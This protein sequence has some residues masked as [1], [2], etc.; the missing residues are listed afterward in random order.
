MFEIAAHYQW[1]DHQISGRFTELAADGLIERTGQTRVK[2][3]TQCAADVWRL[4]DSRAGSAE[5][6]LGT[7]R[8]IRRRWRFRGKGCL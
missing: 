7:C 3:E 6:D 5:R 2:P 8:G 1:F 4:K